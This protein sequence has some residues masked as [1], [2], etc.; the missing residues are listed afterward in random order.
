L[1]VLT[2]TKAATAQV[3]PAAIEETAGTV[4]IRAAGATI[5][6]TKDKVG[7]TVEHGGRKHALEP[8]RN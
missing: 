7:G 2:A 1:N 8:T 3:P 4:V 6:F 5:T